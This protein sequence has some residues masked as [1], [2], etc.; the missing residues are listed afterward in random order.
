MT[1]KTGIVKYRL[2]GGYIDSD[3]TLHREVEMVP[4]GG[5][6]EEILAN[7]GNQES[8]TL[9]TAVL[10][11]CIHR[12]GNISP[13]TEAMVRGLLV[14]DR[15]YLLL[16]LREL[17]FGNLVRATIL[18]PWPKCGASVD[19]DFSLSDI[20]IREAINK[21]SDYRMQLSGEAAF[22]DIDGK[23]ARE[24]RFRL[25]RGDDQEAISLLFTEN[26]AK[27]LS[28]LFQR[29][30]VAMGSCEYP[31]EEL[32]E[33]LSPLARMEIERKMARCTECS[34]QFDAPFD[35]QDFFFGEL[36]ISRDL[37]YR[38]VH[39]LAYHYHWSERE[40]MEMPREK[41]RTYLDILADEIEGLND[42]I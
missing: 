19:I 32:V 21:G 41:R 38:E 10:S 20:P 17:T 34:R 8:A 24:I 42:A 7:G 18:C 9:V 26:E 5:R 22:T 33:R 2:P 23:P 29:C 27:A 37:L 15:Q 1:G 6:E 36:K 4:L 35:L 11:R 31:S 28:C 16:K 25:P 14:A 30:I 12:I 39:Y 40:I 13:V 3:G